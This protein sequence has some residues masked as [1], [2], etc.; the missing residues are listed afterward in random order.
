MRIL[1]GIVM[2]TFL[3]SSARG[4]QSPQKPPAGGAPST[5][6]V[7][8][9]RAGV[10]ERE[11]FKFSGTKPVSPRRGQRTPKK[12]RDVEPTYPEL[13]PGTLGSG[14]WIGE[15]LLAADGTVSRVWT[16]RDVRFTPPFPAFNQAIVDAIRRWE[17]EPFVVNSIA[18]PVCMTVTVIV[19]WR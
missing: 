1:I 14:G 17:Y 19:H 7:Q 13:P 16:V 5:Q 3:A 6:P 11:G 15:V 4:Q 18:R 9:S 12:I 10:C 8:H 2:A